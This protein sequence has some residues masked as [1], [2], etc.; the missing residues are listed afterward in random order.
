VSEVL[1]EASLTA[2]YERNASQTAQLRGAL[3]GHRL[4]DQLNALFKE[5]E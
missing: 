3:A 4:A 2:D 1:T 5:T